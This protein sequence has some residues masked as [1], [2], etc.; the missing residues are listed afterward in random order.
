MSTGLPA[1]S[2]FT[3]CGSY[4]G[5]KVT[6]LCE[7][8]SHTCE[9]KTAQLAQLAA[10]GVTCLL[11]SLFYARGLLHGFS[12]LGSLLLRSASP[13][14]IVLLLLVFVVRSGGRALG[15]CGLFRPLCAAWARLFWFALLACSRGCSCC[16]DGEAPRKRYVVAVARHSALGDGGRAIP[17]RKRLSCQW[18]V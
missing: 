9:A 8:V 12:V 10:G 13:L 7:S 6:P 4:G 5:G 3:P 17:F 2:S 18:P 16:H 11:R 14:V 15:C 1:Y